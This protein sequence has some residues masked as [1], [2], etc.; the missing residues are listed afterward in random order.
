[1]TRT[2][3]RS[4]LALV[5]IVSLALAACGQKPGVHIATSSEGAGLEAGAQAEE[6]GG[7]LAEG[8][9]GVEAAGGEAGGGK[10]TGGGATGGSTRSSSGS[11][12]DRTGVTDTTITVGLHAPLTGAAPFPATAFEKGREV[13]W[14]WSGAPKIHGRTVDLEFEND[15]YNPFTAVDRCRVMAEREKAFALIGG[16]G[17]DQV[18]ACARWAATKR[19]PYLSAG[20]T[21]VGMRNL[22][23]YF[24]ISMSYKQQAPLLWQFIVSDPRLD[25][26]KVAMIRTDT[27]NFEDAHT[28]FLQAV[29]ASGKK[30]LVDRKMSKNPSQTE[31]QQTALA[32]RQNDAQVVFVLVAPIH[33]I[34]LGARLDST[35]RPWFV[36]VG[37]TKGLNDALDQGCRA[38]GGEGTGAGTNSAMHKGLFFSPFPGLDRIDALD[39][40]YNKAYQAMNNTAGDDL[41]MALW[42]LNKTLHLLLEK[43]GKDL[44]RQ[45]FL[46]AAEQAS[47]SSGIFP[48]LQY[49]PQNHFGANQVWVLRANCET[50]VHSTERGLSSSF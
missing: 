43:A 41:G 30:L 32:L 14:K 6:G 2:P 44:S 29:R 50:Q 47:V 8:G 22:K 26:N 12:A 16:G 1:M 18:Q 20:V 38:T 3:L 11:S 39:P 42:G 10:S 19:I 25:E 17:T 23:N 45:S 27:P 46:A 9:G 7:V 37:I 35:Y 28:A 4:V 13:Y 31:Y 5:A 34:Q 36:G 48:P 40:N 49:S 33:Y 21:E 15:D 24:A